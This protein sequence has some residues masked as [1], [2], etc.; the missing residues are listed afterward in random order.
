MTT[1]NPASET[2]PGVQAPAKNGTDKPL[3]VDEE[4]ALLRAEDDEKEKKKRNADKVRELAMR[5]ARKKY[6]EE[7]GEEGV[8]FAIIET[9]AEPIVVKLGGPAQYKRYQA[10][11]REKN[12]MP[13][14]E[15]MH[16]FLQPSIV[17]PA[18]ERFEELVDKHAGLIAVGVARLIA[19]Y[20][21]DRDAA[22]G[23]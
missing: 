20:Q 21:G 6:E 10:A 19:L 8:A 4:L 5:K 14:L 7:L 11:K 22:M 12:D 17:S 13:S 2:K 1:Q 15:T 23:K 16:A 9:S 18:L 3:S